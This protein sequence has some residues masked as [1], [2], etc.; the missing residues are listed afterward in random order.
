MNSVYITVYYNILYNYM[1][2][3]NLE[4]DMTIEKREERFL[5]KSVFIIFTPLIS[6]YL[7]R[8]VN[9]K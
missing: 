7:N 8:D 2:V 3:Y 6:K 9:K 1:S 5:R 4:R